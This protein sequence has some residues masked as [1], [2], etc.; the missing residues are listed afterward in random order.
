MTRAQFLTAAAILIACGCTESSLGPGSGKSVGP[1][2]PTPPELQPSVIT[3]TVVRASSGPALQMA[4]RLES[5]D[6]VELVGS[7][8]SRLATLDGAQVQLRG[9]WTDQLLD[10]PTADVLSAFS[11]EEFLV[12]AVGGRPAMDGVLG[13]DAG[14]Y[15]LDPTGGGD[16]FWFEDAPSE[17]DANIGRRIWVTGSAEDPP[18]RFAA[19]E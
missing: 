17:F 13:Q 4:L 1:R 16:V 5:G 18:V 6:L 19:I 15:Y 10:P 12:L 14:R 11:V 9:S 2:P 3:G 8:A 7:E